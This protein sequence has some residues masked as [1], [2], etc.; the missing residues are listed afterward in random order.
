MAGWLIVL[1]AVTSI[2]RFIAAMLGL[3]G[4]SMASK[5]QQP[6]DE[7]EGVDGQNPETHDLLR[8]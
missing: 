8:F 1:L 2:G 6:R 5:R 7:I 4:L 3:F